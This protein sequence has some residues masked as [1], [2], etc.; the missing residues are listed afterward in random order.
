IHLLNTLDAAGDEYVLADRHRLQQILLNLLSNA[1]KY[2]RLGG[3]V[4]VA[5]RRAKATVRIEVTDTGPGIAH[6]QLDRLFVPFERLGAEH[7]SVEG[8]G[9]GLALSRQ[10][11]EAMG[12]ALGVDTE[13]GRG[14]TFYVELPVAEGPVERL[15][16]L[17]LAGTPGQPTEAA[18]APAHKV[19]Y[20]ED[21]LANVSL[22]RRI[23]SERD[24]V[25]LVPAMQGRLGVELGRE[26]RPD[27]VL[28]DLHLPDISGSEVLH[29]LR[30][31]PATASTPVVI[32][33][34]DATCGQVQRLLG[35][36]AL[37]YLTKPIEVATLLRLVDEH[38]LGRQPA[39]A[40]AAPT[41]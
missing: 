29:Q 32:V 36:G 2:N 34:A 35:A 10:L 18:S 3:S 7:T 37:A 6:E 38:V 9:I 41:V 31:E 19:L 30:E 15:E 16:R 23:L 26:H 21:N 27:L 1:V 17:K 11:A 20:I 8:T 24:G 12:G 39:G 14:S 22:V 33:S 40:P 25:E 13:M 28:L 4:A 5:C